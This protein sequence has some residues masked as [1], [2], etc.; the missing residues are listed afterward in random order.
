MREWLVTKADADDHREYQ[1]RSWALPLLLGL[2]VVV[3]IDEPVGYLG[4][5]IRQKL[6]ESEADEEHGKPPQE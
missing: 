6:N 2:A 5:Q 1:T 4:G 3:A